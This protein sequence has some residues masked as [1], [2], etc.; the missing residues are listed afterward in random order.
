ML[1]GEHLNYVQIGWTAE[2]KVTVRKARAT[3]EADSP[4]AHS[5]S[6]PPESPRSDAGVVSVDKPVTPPAR[7]PYSDVSWVGDP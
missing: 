3:N 4:D 5:L 1:S 6:L 7:S 2:Q